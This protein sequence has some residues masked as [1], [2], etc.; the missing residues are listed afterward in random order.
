[1]TKIIRRGA[2]VDLSSGKEDTAMTLEETVAEIAR[3]SP[4]ALEVMKA[5]G[6]NHCCGGHLTLTEAAAAAGVS[7]DKVRQA[8]EKAAGAEG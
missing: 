1:M 4:A 8:V 6:I 2:R 3:R 5:M 7:V